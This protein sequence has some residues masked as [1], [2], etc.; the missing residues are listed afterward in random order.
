[1]SSS[2]FALE[3]KVR[4]IT[5]KSVGI[6]KYSGPLHFIEGEW[7]GLELPDASG[8]ND[9]EVMGQRYFTCK[10]NHGVFIKIA[11][12][13]AVTESSPTLPPTKKVSKKPFLAVATVATSF[14]KPNRLSMAT[15]VKRQN[16][17]TANRQSLTTAMLKVSKFVKIFRI[18]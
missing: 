16:T 12:A 14:Q 6:V 15:P 4:V 5:S 18:N 17:A 13:R 8:K 1:M 3:Q 11:N 2:G 10:P 9:G 7:L